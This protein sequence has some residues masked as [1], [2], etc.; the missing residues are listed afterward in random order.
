M[1][2]SFLFDID[3]VLVD[4]RSSYID[5]IRKTVDLY[6]EKVFGVRRGANL[7]LSREDVHQF[8]LLGGFNND[9]D[10]VYGLLLYFS[11]FL[12]C[13]GGKKISAADLRYF[14]NTPALR[15]RV[16]V[17]CGMKNLEALLGKNPKI[18]YALAKSLFQEI[19]LG[20]RLFRRLY[21]KTP[22]WV[23]AKGLIEKEKPLVPKRTLLSLKKGGTR[24]GIV[25][26]RTRFEAEYVLKHFGIHSL[27]D[28]F[29]THDE[30]EKAEKKS[31]LTLRKPHPYSVL[32]CAKALGAASF[33]YVGD[34]PDD[35]KA[36]NAAKKRIRILSC[37][38]LYGQDNPALMR[39]ALRQAKADYLIRRP[40]ELL[41]LA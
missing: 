34:L 9:W 32:R 8:K 11:T 26:G 12:D 40:S 15:K 39:R 2:K 6:L 41:K 4:V 7:L 38:V 5:A 35:I 27:F 1:R 28:A 16:P 20:E 22:E 10:S 24:F 17:P 13:P 37:G 31:G 3:G 14:K 25:T 36:A 21:R 23:R 29:V 33:L 19:Y 30:V 18:D